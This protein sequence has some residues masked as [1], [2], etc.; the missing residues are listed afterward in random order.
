VCVC[1]RER[2]RESASERARERE[3]VR[4]AVW[5]TAV[6]CAA[7]P[8]SLQFFLKHSHWSYSTI[9]IPPEL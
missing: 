5:L 9:A 1:E 4:E 2:A 3:C 7:P 8:A 6:I